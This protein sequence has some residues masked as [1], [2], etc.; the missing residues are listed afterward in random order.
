[1]VT[2]GVDKHLRRVFKLWEEKVPC[3][4]FEITSKSTAVDD[5]IKS[6]LYASLGVR[7]YFL[8]DP[9][10]EYITGSPWGFRLDGM[11]Y[12]P[13]SLDDN[14]NLFSEELGLILKREEYLLRLVDPKTNQAVPSL[15]EA[16]SMAEQAE[17]RAEQES[18]RAEQEA[19][20]ADRLA[21]KLREMGIDPESA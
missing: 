18:Q 3:V 13:I 6:M 10:E 1:M 16:V 14:G 4:I 19:R 5:I 7:E 9:L 12:T 20:R 15:N 21:A 11:A 2:K 8:F 17:Q